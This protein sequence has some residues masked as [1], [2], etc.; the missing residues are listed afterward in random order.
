[1]AEKELQR[2]LETCLY[3]RSDNLIQ[4][5][6]DTPQSYVILL[7]MWTQTVSLID[8]PDVAE[9]VERYGVFDGPLPKFVLVGT[10]ELKPGKHLTGVLCFA[11]NEFHAHL[12]AKKM[13]QHGSVQIERTKS[14][15]DGATF[16]V[17]AVE[18]F[19]RMFGSILQK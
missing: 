4:K 12:L 1:M 11:D 5:V 19:D 17:D 7:S 15:P 3:Q 2:R 8:L 13:G 9:L 10:L 16:S 6:V 18:H 14:H